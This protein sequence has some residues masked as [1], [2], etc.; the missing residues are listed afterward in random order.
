MKETVEQTPVVQSSS[1]GRWFEPQRG[2]LIASH[3]FLYP[4][5]AL[6]RRDFKTRYSATTLGIGWAVGQPL[7]LLL[8]YT[9]AFSIVLKVRF[10]P[11]DNIF[12]S[13]IYLLC[14]LVPYLAVAES[15]YRASTCL[16]DN[17]SLIEKVVFPAQVL[18][19]VP[20]VGTTVTESIA[21]VLLAVFAV[22]SG[23]RITA[24]VLF[25]PL[26]ILLRALFTTGLVWL[27]SVLNVF[28][29]DLGQVLGLLLTAWMFLTPIFYPSQL[30]PPGLNWLATINPL[31]HFV[32]AYRAV[33][34][35]E[36]SPLSHLPALVVWAGGLSLLGLW[37]FNRTVERAKDFL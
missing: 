29:R 23:T 33:I 13:A 8:L 15:T 12:V 1:N 11:G 31:Y 30:V 16:R 34:M 27:L 35:E 9:F 17:R 5:L 24:W 7:A 28:I 20:V 3:R 2:T 26:L 4:L 25:L 10:R 18:P 22:L 21:L 32:S 6:V 14:G 36:T 19:A 37:F